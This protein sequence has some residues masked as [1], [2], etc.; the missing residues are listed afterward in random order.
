[1]S[2]RN[3]SRATT[4]VDGD[5][6]RD[7]EQLGRRLEV[8]RKSSGRQA[9]LPNTAMAAA[10]LRAL[11]RL[12]AR[13]PNPSTAIILSTGVSNIGEVELILCALGAIRNY[14]RAPR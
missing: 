13:P 12:A 14:Q 6:P 4:A 2:A 3:A 7:C 9:G 10:F 1:V 5:D 8:L 11:A